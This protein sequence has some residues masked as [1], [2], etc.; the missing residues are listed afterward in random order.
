MKILEQLH[1]ISDIG[2]SEK[3]LQREISTSE[4]WHLWDMLRARNILQ[5]IQGFLQIHLSSFVQSTNPAIR[6]LF[7]D[8]YDPPTYRI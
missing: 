8:V 7:K 5:G 2:K 4:A 1:N 3:E 6:Q